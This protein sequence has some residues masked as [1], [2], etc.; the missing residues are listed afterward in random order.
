MRQFL[1][2]IISLALAGCST[3]R[4]AILL[5]TPPPPPILQ[6]TVRRQLLAPG[7]PAGV[8]RVIPWQYSPSIVTSNYCWHL[9]VSV[10][11]TNW[12]D[13][14]DCQ[15]GEITVTASLPWAFFRLKGVQ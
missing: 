8:D 11:L 15:S 1:V 4:P 9:Q 2:C 10:D 5:P 14:P 3:K 12:T 6:K 13:V 7:T